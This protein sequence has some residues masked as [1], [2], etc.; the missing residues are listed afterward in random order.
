MLSS[1]RPGPR[2]CAPGLVRLLVRI[3]LTSIRLR[4]P[5]FLGGG[6]LLFVV[7]LC[8]ELGANLRHNKGVYVIFWTFR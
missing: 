8:G 7:V 2:I 3:F 4:T 5:V 1:D 6:A